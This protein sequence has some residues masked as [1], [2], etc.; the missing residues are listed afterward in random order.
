[1]EIP[2]TEAYQSRDSVV[3]MSDKAQGYGLDNVVKDAVK[4]GKRT[5]GET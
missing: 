3:N 5:N 2:N 1:M 4:R